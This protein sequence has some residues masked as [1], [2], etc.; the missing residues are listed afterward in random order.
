MVRNEQV[1]MNDFENSNL[2]NIN[3]G[4]LSQFNNSTVIGN[5]N[6]DGFTLFL[7][8]VGNHDYVFVSFDL[9]IHGSWEGNFNGIPNNDKV[10]KLVM[11]FKPDIEL[12]K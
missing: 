10:D 5:F 11:E 9:Y 6:N 12:I 1:Y 4:G 7:D 3:G 2:E 8:D